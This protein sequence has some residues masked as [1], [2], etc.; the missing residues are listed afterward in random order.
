M[1]GDTNT[2]DAVKSDIEQKLNAIG[3]QV[4]WVNDAE[5]HPGG[6]NVHCGT[7]TKKTPV[8]ADFTACLP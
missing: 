5:Y 8:C 6:G 2:P 1:I 3:I 7:N 4:A